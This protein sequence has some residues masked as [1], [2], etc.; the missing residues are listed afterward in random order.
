VSP[1]VAGVEKDH[2]FRVFD[3]FARRWYGRP[4]EPVVK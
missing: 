3:E 4:P 2:N 1:N